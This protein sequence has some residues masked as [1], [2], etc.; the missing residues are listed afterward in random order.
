MVS[1]NIN[2]FVLESP[3]MKRVKSFLWRGGMMTL[4][5]AIA[6]AGNNLG[7]LELNNISTM[8]LGL[9]LSEISKHLNSK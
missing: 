4:A 1:T 8:I 6:W 9:V 3:L 2:E 7:L 5:F